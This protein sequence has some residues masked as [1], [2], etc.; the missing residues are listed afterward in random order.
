MFTTCP[1]MFRSTR[2]GPDWILYLQKPVGCAAA[3]LRR[4]RQL[5]EIAL[6]L[7]KQ[8]RNRGAALR[9]ARPT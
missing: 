3:Q 1:R 9:S 2:C 8:V 4:M 5:A 7:F 6:N